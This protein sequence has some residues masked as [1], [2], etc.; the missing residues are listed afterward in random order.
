ML[1]TL[2]EKVSR[3]VTDTSAINQNEQRKLIAHNLLFSEIQYAFL[4]TFYGLSV[5]NN[6]KY[7][8]ILT[9]F[10]PLGISEYHQRMSNQFSNW[11]PVPR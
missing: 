9:V 1:L 10:S 5:N 6:R 2:I 8:D 4:F 11:F 7:K 3:A